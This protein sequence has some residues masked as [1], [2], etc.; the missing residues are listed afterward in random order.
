[1]EFFTKEQ[2]QEIIN[3]YKDGIDMDEIMNTYNLKSSEEVKIRKILKKEQLDRKYNIFTDELKKR[4]KSLYNKGYLHY[5]ICNSLLISNECLRKMIARKELP[6]RSISD[7]NRRYYRNSN[8]FDVIDTPNKAYFLGF[9]YSDGNVYAKDN[10]HCMTITL[11]EKDVTILAQ[12]KNELEY[13]GPLRK[14]ELS[15]KKE[16]YKD[17]WTLSLTDEQICNS[18]IDKGVIPQKSLKLLFPTFLDKELLS[19]FI[20]GYFDG[21][22]NI[23]H[24]KSPTHNQW[25]IQIVGTINFC[26]ALHKILLEL[27]VKNTIKTPSYYK[28]HDNHNNDTTKILYI[29]GTLNCV[30]FGDYIYNNSDMKLERK[31]RDYIIMKELNKNLIHVNG[32]DE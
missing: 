22:G 13:E 19:H 27:N 4:I 10:K 2:K 1:M 31:Y 7:I 16:T 11:Q 29:S 30:K 18:L 15:K 25:S 32:L 23:Y 8:Y 5:E 3:M 14:I 17:Q 21:D 12:M 24:Y 28:T 9:L 20:R 6:K 26:E